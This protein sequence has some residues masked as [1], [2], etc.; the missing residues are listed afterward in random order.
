MAM[1]LLFGVLIDSALRWLVM[2]SN[3]KYLPLIGTCIT[4][5]TTLLGMALTGIGLWFAYWNVANPFRLELYKRQTETVCEI[6]QIGK[7][8]YETLFYNAQAR[9]ETGTPIPG[10]ELKLKSQFSQTMKDKQ[11]ALP[12]SVI[13]GVWDFFFICNDFSKAIY[14]N[15]DPKDRMVKE[16]KQFEQDFYKFLNV[17]RDALHTDRLTEGTARL[18][19]APPSKKA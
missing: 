13:R 12:V 1:L 4:A 8:L 2:Q 14:T 5:I 19:A 16:R 9:A 10:D 7:E 3:D 11:V 17:C 6:S 18:L 15:E